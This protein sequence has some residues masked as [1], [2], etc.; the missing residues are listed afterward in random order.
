M[1]TPGR[2]K[3]KPTW[4]DKLKRKPT[5]KSK[6]PNKT[7]NNKNKDRMIHGK[8]TIDFNSVDLNIEVFCSSLLILNESNYS[9]SICKLF[10]VLILIKPCLYQ[11]L[12]VASPLLPT[13]L[14]PLLVVPELAFFSMKIAPFLLGKRYIGWTRL[15][16][17]AVRFIYLEGYFVCCSV[18]F[19]QSRNEITPLS[20]NT[21]IYSMIFVAIG[22]LVEYLIFAAGMVYLVFVKVRSLIRKEKSVSFIFYKKKHGR[23]ARDPEDLNQRNFVDEDDSVGEVLRAN[24]RSVLEEDHEDL[25]AV[26]KRKERLRKFA[27]NWR[28]RSQNCTKKRK[29]QEK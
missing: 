5:Q 27:R 11:V 13:F 8:K 23:R 9:S 3:F 22:L 26:I 28:K 2:R 4:I 18:L 7:N 1:I 15:M 17:E 10:N 24:S 14:L 20:R 19:S 12:V 16:M 29:A 21:Q 6:T 25:G